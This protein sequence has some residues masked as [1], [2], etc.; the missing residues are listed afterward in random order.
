MS[1]E[2]LDTEPSFGLNGKSESAPSSADFYFESTKVYE[3]PTSNGSKRAFLRGG[4]AKEVPTLENGLVDFDGLRLY[5]HP[6]PNSVPLQRTHGW[7]YHH[8][9]HPESSFKQWEKP[10]EERDPRLVALRIMFIALK[11]PTRQLKL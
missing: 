8:I 7:K 4:H 2:R 1:A 11:Y 3:T 10:L 9:N 6:N 5:L